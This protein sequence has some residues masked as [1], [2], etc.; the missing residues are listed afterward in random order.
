MSNNNNNVTP[1][2]NAMLRNMKMFKDMMRLSE[3]KRK[4]GYSKH[5]TEKNV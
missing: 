2:I 1:N 5:N 4:N 3:E